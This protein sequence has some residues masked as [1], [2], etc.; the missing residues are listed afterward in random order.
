MPSSKKVTKNS[1]NKTAQPKTYLEKISLEVSESQSKLSM[2]LGA[3]IILVIGILLF[4]YFSRGKQSLGPAQ[5]TE[6]QD[7]QDTAENSG[8][9][10]TIKEGDT[11]FLIAQKFYGD[12]YK[13]TE[14]VKLNNLTNPDLIEVGQ[15]LDV[16]KIET[17]NLSE[18]TLTQNAVSTQINTT[19]TQISAE[20]TEWGPRITEN[21]YTVVAGDWLSKIAAR[22]YGDTMSYEKLAKAN[23]MTDPNLIEPGTILSIPR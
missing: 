6:T 20:S 23:N 14:L 3:L 17:D 15:V 9:K 11:L 4:N 12:G 2:V 8:G 1:S 7:S 21:K 5:S 22:A 10:Y 19:Q 18:N 13:F 16:Q